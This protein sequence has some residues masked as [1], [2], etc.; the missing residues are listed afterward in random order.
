MNKNSRILIVGNKGLISLTLENRLK[1][2]GFSNLISLGLSEINL[3]EKNNVASFFKRVKPDYCFLTH[4]KEGGIEA[5]ISY[6][7]ELIYANL[8]IQANIIHSA[9]ENKV[10]K[11][12]FFASSCVYPKDCR[13]PMKEEYL[14]TGRPEPTN[15]PYAIAKIS[16]IKMCQAYNKQYG[17]KFISVIPAT[18]FGPGDNFDF[19]TSHVIPALIRKFHEAKI[20]KFPKVKVW[21]T[22]KP[23]REFVFADDLIDASLFLIKYINN[24]EVINVGT[25]SDIS[26]RGLAKEIK[27]VAGFDGKIEF[28]V[29]RPDGALRKLLDTTK[30]NSLGWQP[31]TEIHSGL[32]NTY[33]WYQRTLKQRGSQ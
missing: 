33:R 29:C 15:E 30:L 9:Y 22:G 2:D 26:I 31:K 5:N 3:T 23:R 19:K 18:V 13:Q 11:L 20:K 6:P 1:Q 12:I 8:S 10:K 32:I 25:G 7:A 27:K 4:I 28:D 16:G 14:F 17:T 21:G 24:A